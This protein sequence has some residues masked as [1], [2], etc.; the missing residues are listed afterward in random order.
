MFEERRRALVEKLVREGYARSEHVINALLRVPRELFVP[1]E[2][3]EL[4][5][6]DTP[7]PIGFGQTISA[8]HMVALMTELAELKPGHKVLEIGAGSGY[9]A[10]VMAEVV[11]PSSA[12]REEWGHVYTVERIKGLVELARRNLRRAG[13]AD[14][15]TVVEG[16]GT[17][18]YSEAAPFD[19]IIVTASA[20]HLP[21]PLAEQLKPRGRIIIPIGDKYLQHLY[22]I[23]KSEE[24]KLKYSKITPCLFVPLIGRYGWRE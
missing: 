6:E 18:G 23:V 7:L 5:Y 15:V 20:P 24:G 19:R 2:L 16:D 8:P 1:E 3:V 14:R 21:P 13:Y 22:L 11:A 10:A 9:H 17:L 4:A 12:P